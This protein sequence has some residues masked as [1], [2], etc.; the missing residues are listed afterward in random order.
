MDGCPSTG[1][2]SAE[3]ESAPLPEE[4]HPLHNPQYLS[5][6]SEWKKTCLTP[7]HCASEITSHCHS[8]R[9]PTDWDGS[10][11]PPLRRSSAEAAPGLSTELDQLLWAAQL[12][13]GTVLRNA[14]DRSARTGLRRNSDT[15][16]TWLGAQ[17][18]DDPYMFFTR[19]R[20][21]EGG[22]EFRIILGY[23]KAVN[24][25]NVTHR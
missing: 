3:A 25:V 21:F 2:R 17:H 9:G 5:L 16:R 6:S 20:Y 10:L 15:A 11:E 8:R 22:S 18:R 19:S 7:N 24:V 1:A 14:P 13:T 4:A 23:V 12:R